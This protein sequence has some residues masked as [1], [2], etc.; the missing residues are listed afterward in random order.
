M[1]LLR[2]CRRPTESGVGTAVCVLT[3][4]QGI[5]TPSRLTVLGWMLSQVFSGLISI[6]QAPTV[7][8]QVVPC[9]IN[10][11]VTSVLWMKNHSY[12]SLN[13]GSSD[14]PCGKPPRSLAG[15]VRSLVCPCPCASSM[16][17]GVSTSPCWWAR[18]SCQ[19]MRPKGQ[20]WSYSSMIPYR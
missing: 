11:E 13:T 20:G 17:L 14:V 2:L 19:T 12:L 6:D 18:L 16:T 9:V 1:Q 8:A 15:G 5:V 10:T 7:Y 4:P 3:H